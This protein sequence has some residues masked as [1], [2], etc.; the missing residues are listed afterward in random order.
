M[1]LDVNSV[2][3]RTNTSHTHFSHCDNHEESGPEAQG[4]VFIIFK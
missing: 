1:M 2:P 4:S 3:L